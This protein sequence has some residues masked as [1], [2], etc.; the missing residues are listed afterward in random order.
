MKRGHL[1]LSRSEK[2][3][4]S[5][6]KGDLKTGHIVTYLLNKSSIVISKKV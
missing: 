4:I 3:E 5:P 2:E 1:P 6:K